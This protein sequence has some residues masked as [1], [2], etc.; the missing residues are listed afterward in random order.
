MIDAEDMGR[1]FN[2]QPQYWPAER[3]TLAPA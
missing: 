3:A 2:G 1:I